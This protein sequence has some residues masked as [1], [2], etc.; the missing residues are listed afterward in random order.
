MGRRMLRIT[1]VLLGIALAGPA[2]AQTDRLLRPGL[3]GPDGRETVAAHDWP[4]RAVGRVN[5]GTLGR[6]QS[7][8]CTGTLVAPK[9]V[10][11]A[12]HCLV[13]ARTFRPLPADLV[14]FVAGWDRGRFLWHAR[15]D[16][17]VLSSELAKQPDLRHIRPGQDWALLRL[18][19]VPDG[20]R[21]V[22]L[23]PAEA[24][25]RVV[26]AGYSRDRA[27]VLTVDRDCRLTRAGRDGVASVHGC[28][29]TRGD[30]GSPL[31]TT[32]LGEPAVAGILTAVVPTGE[33]W[34]A[35]AVTAASIR[36]A[37]NRLADD[38]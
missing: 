8:F 6:G 29:V 9:V 25:G 34:V 20:Q 12:A 23:A 5:R 2:L 14:H 7:G 19:S 13:N 3:A 15:A 24:T 28:S 31:L 38:R 17:I 27:H 21:P 35:L 26:Q 18:S 32:K 4:W 30:S 36:T 10:L 11:T 33:G 1:C 37:L 16:A 22:P